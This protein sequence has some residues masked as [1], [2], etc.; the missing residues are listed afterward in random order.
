MTQIVVVNISQAIA[1]TPATLQQMGALI[2]QGGT[3]TAAGTISLLTQLSDL[4]VLTPAALAIT[5]LAWNS[6]VVTATTAAPHGL[7][8]GK[9]IPVTIAGALPVGYNGAF[10]A[11]VTGAS[12]FTYPLIANPGSETAP[13]T[14]LNGSV[15]ELN[16]MATTFFAQG[17]GSSVYVLECGPT[18]V[19]GGV[20][21]LSAY[22]TANPNSNYRPGAA[23]FFYQYLVPREWDGNAN[24]LSLLATQNALTARTYFYVTTTLATYQLYPDLDKCVVALIESPVYGAYPA[25]AL[26]AISASGL[27]V[28]ATTTTAHGVLP[29]QWFTIAGVTPIGYNGTFLA[30]PGTTGSTLIYNVLAAPGSESIL[31]TLVASFVANAGVGALE[32]SHA[33]DFFVSLHYRPDVTNRVTPFEYSFLFDVTPFP[34]RNNSALLTTLKAQDISVVDTGSEGG[35]S[36]TILSGGNM[37]DGNPLNYWYA[38]DWLQINIDLD[39]ANA[40]INGSNDPLNPLYYNQD[41]INRLQQVAAATINRGVSFG[42][43]LFPALQTEQI[44][45]AFAQSLDDGAY[46]GYSP[47]NAV[48]FLVYAAANPGNYKIGLYGGLSCSF[49]PARGFDQIIFD[50]SVSQFVAL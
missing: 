30:L 15:T 37:S 9:V 16:Q 35:I 14:W 27:V 40:I 2:S 8:N 22:I 25:N 48:P 47:I 31:G 13:G 44:G 34:T 41:G 1:P 4:T 11:T 50:I 46:N 38:V 43:V 32:F 19:N 33:A 36:N 23:G 12:T 28:T 26:T 7:P 29:G 18:D 39:I 6:A 42:L 3:N 45:T 5:S 24:F 17:S 10:N 20:A 21:F 49:V